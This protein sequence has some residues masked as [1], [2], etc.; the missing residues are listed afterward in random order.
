[1]LQN[2]DS[3]RAR[4]I[5]QCGC[6]NCAVDDRSTFDNISCV[7]KLLDNVDEL[8]RMIKTYRKCGKHGAMWWIPGRK[9]VLGSSL[10]EYRAVHRFPMSALNSRGRKLDSS[11]YL[12]H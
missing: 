9:L 5:V 2:V 8:S 4:N 11:W 1:M 12:Q 10:Y 6:V 7:N 3:T